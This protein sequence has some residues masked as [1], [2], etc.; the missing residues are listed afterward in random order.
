L[1]KQ[2]LSSRE[3]GLLVAN[4]VGESGNRDPNQDN[5]GNGIDPAI[6]LLV[7]WG[8]LVRHITSPIY[9]CTAYARRVPLYEGAAFY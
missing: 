4:P 5:C 7:G 9:L 2:L 3:V 1:P 8:F 6:A